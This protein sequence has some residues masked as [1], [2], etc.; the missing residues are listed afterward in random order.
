MNCSVP[1]AAAAQVLRICE[2]SAVLGEGTACTFESALQTRT[3]T[4]DGRDLSFT[5]PLPRSE[6]EPGGDYAF[7]VAPIYPADDL[8]E[9]SCEI[10]N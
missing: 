2:T 6:A 8:A 9:V 3:I 5:C 1:Q 10:T 7:Y 4:S